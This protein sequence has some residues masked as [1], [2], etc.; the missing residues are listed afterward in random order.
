VNLRLQITIVALVVTTMALAPSL[1]MNQSAEAASVEKCKD[2]KKSTLLG[3]N[4]NNYLDGCKD[5]WF[6]WDDCGNGP[7][8]K[9]KGPYA[10]G[11]KD[12]WKKRQEKNPTR[13][14]CPNK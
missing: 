9:D 13:G 12:G 14:S 3:H 1:V 11:Y 2:P 7:N 10:E 5:G 4:Y 8:P 6:N